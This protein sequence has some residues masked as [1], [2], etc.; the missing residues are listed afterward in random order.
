MKWLFIPLLTVFL[1]TPLMAADP[2]PRTLRIAIEGAFPPFSSVTPEGELVGFDVDMARL[3]CTVI[4]AQCTL[5]KQDWDGLIPALLARRVDAIVASMS[6]TEERKKSV[7]FTDKYYQTP[8]RY[9]R[10]KGAAI[11]ATA[12]GLRGKAI[13]VQRATIFEDYVR[14]NYGDAVD[15]RQ[16]DDF[17]KIYLDLQSGRLDAA[18]LD[19]LSVIGSFLNTPAGAD[20]EFFGPIVSD[21]RW[22]GEGIGIAL[23]P[24]EADLHAQFNAAIQTIRADGRYDALRVRYFDFDIY[25]D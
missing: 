11:E 14:M 17:E 1:A 7:L 9:L 13:G 8:A 19:G 24:D 22:V 23:R 3:L 5:V 10:R 6:I 25:G 15:L 12:E 18:F 4:D 16:Y 2:D 21:E 20:F